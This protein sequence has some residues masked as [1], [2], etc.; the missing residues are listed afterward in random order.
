MDEKMIMPYGASPHLERRRGDENKT[1]G[2]GI[3]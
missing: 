3:S 2:K 1:E